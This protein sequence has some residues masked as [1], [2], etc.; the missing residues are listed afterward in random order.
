M[1]LCY[2]GGELPSITQEQ[3]DDDSV[4]CEEVLDFT[5]S[6]SVL[7]NT[8]GILNFGT[9]TY[10]TDLNATTTTDLLSQVVTQ[11][12]LSIRAKTR[13]LF[14]VQYNGDHDFTLDFIPE[15]T[16]VL[17]DSQGFYRL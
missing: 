17:L 6:Q 11:S 15:A 4:F 10:T 12:P 13:G 3:A 8:L 2:G 5:T 14:Q 9:Q 1:L 7:S 16:G